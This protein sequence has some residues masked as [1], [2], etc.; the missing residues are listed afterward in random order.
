[1]APTATDDVD[2]AKLDELPEDLFHLI[3]SR[4]DGSSAFSV[5]HAQKA[6]SAIASQH[7]KKATIPVHFMSS[8]SPLTSSLVASLD[9]IRLVLPAIETP[10]LTRQQRAN[11]SRVQNL[12]CHSNENALDRWMDELDSFGS[13]PVSWTSLRIKRAD[14]FSDSMAQSSI[15]LSAIVR[16]AAACALGPGL[17]T[18]SLPYLHPIA[19]TAL[20]F[21]TNLKKISLVLA[22]GT[23]LDQLLQI[24]T[25][26]N[27]SLMTAEGLLYLI[28]S[29]DQ[30]ER[31]CQ[32]KH[33]K[34]L[35]LQNVFLHDCEM[36]WQSFSSLQELSQLRVSSPMSVSRLL[37]LPKSLTT[38]Q[39]P[40]FSNGGLNPDPLEEARLL[41][42]SSPSIPYPSI[43]MLK[44]IR[45]K[46]TI[47]EDDLVTLS[48]YFLCLESITIENIIL[49]Q[50]TLDDIQSS[51]FAPKGLP[52]LPSVTSLRMTGHHRH[53]QVLGLLFPNLQKLEIQSVES[54][55]INT[56]KSQLLEIKVVPLPF[57]TSL[58]WPVG[59][60]LPPILLAC[61]SIK[62]LTVMSIN[63]AQRLD[64]V[65]RLPHPD[66]KLKHHDGSLSKSKTL[67]SSSTSLTLD[68]WPDQL[69][70]LELGFCSSTT[71]RPKTICRSMESAPPK[72]RANITK[73]TLRDHGP[74]AIFRP[75]Q[76]MSS[77]VVI[78][79]HHQSASSMNDCQDETGRVVD[80]SVAS[81]ALTS[82]R[83][84]RSLTVIGAKSIDA[85]GLLQAASKSSLLL[86]ALI[87]QGC[88]RVNRQE[89]LRIPG[90]LNRPHLQVSC[91]GFAADLF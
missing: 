45:C 13:K 60:S 61:P 4:L 44:E 27:I 64:D 43:I 7:I 56:T 3:C 22:D 55:P 16:I 82:F 79:S 47:T 81:S 42:C 32:L 88:P 80:G 68:W 59:K 50:T 46:Q 29:L 77:G 49:S 65:F 18:L 40:Y 76:A 48:R 41:L 84:L 70:E 15:G 54:P 66:D 1:M 28:L 9:S 33:L 37:Q 25:L 10:A 14:G 63:C 31:I 85:P 6:L 83:M 51:S 8:M 67:A 19:A 5:R 21:F 12:D 24:R 86:E 39:L 87:V 53:W 35:S 36:T 23:C 72:C 30:I 74:L 38:L 75:K 57:L 73:L 26:E 89:L 91:V 90:L 17:K 62:Q 71:F 34:S 20:P 11:K 52:D 58:T 78:S 2:A 69:S